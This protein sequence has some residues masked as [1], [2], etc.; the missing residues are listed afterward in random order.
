MAL[1]RGA[2]ALYLCVLALLSLLSLLLLSLS[3]LLSWCNCKVCRTYLT[4]SW[5]SQFS[6]LCDFY[7]HLL[8]SSKTQTIKVHVLNNIIT[9]NPKNVEH[10]LKTQF[11]NYPKGKPFHTILHDLL[12]RGIFNV[13]G[14][15]WRFQRKMASYELGSQAV[16]AMVAKTV[17][18][19]I[20]TRLEPIL[21]DSV[22]KGSK[23]DLQDVLKKFTF[24]NIC[25]I[26]FGLD[27]CCLELT[28]PIS[29]FA[30]AFDRASHLCAGRAVVAPSLIWKIKKFLN[31]G[32]ERSLREA[33]NMVDLMAIEVIRQRKVVGSEASDLLSRFMTTVSDDKFLRDIIVSF[34][35]AGRDTVASALTSFFWLMAKH[36]EVEEKVHD[37][38]VRVMGKGRKEV[39][40]S[41]GKLREMHYLHA[42]LSESMRLYPPVQFDSKFAEKDDIL[43]DGTVVKKGTRVTYHPYAMGRME[44]I[45]G[46]DCMEFNP[47]RWLEN[48]FFVPEN[49]FK[50]PVFQAGLRVCLGKE[51]AFL[52]M[53]SVVASVVYKHKLVLVNPDY[54]PRFVTSLTANVSGGLEVFVESRS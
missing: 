44:S 1:A 34:L 16:R 25:K 21:A 14:E 19:E 49:P 29:E 54:T 33:I 10:I 15:L 48:G 26:S 8:K 31:L 46:K 17:L 12:G 42:A 37:E 47:E 28:Q 27:P 32:S 40:A 7:T 2:F 43:P 36:P 5:V 20:E 50:Y 52:Q 6:N 41:Y 9:A 24:D 18:A 30:Q 11:E 4:K 39:I 13:D 35:L 51:M 53:K 22:S 23:L 45:W 3:K 38:I